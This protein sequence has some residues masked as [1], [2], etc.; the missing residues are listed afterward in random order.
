MGI[1][2]SRQTVLLTL[3]LFHAT[4]IMYTCQTTAG[5]SMSAN[6]SK[7]IIISYIKL[8]MYKKTKIYFSLDYTIY[9]NVCIYILFIFLE[10]YLKL[11]NV[12]NMYIF[13]D[14]TIRKKMIS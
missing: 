3:N 8:Y 9:K 7:Y 6:A 4:P 14:Q 13:V 5:G 12:Y 1:Y 2:P 11:K 10:Y